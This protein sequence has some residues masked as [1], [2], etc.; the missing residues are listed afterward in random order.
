MRLFRHIK[1]AFKGLIRN[2]WIAVSTIT[3]VTITL[4][5]TGVFI[6]M[7]LNV[8][9]FTKNIESTVK[10]VAFVDSEA[11]QETVLN[12]DKQLQQIEG[13][14]LV[15]LATKEEELDKFIAYFGERG[16]IFE[17]Y[18]GE[19]N[20]L[21]TAFYIDA[22]DPQYVESITQTAKTIEGVSLVTY[23]GTSVD[24]MFSLFENVRFGMLV[25]IVGLGVLAVFLVS[26]T[27]KMSITA[28]RREIEIMRLVGA[29]NMYIRVPFMIE[30][31][32]IGV[33]GSIIPISIV[34]I[35]YQKLFISVKGEFFTSML[36]LIEPM[37]FVVNVSSYLLLAGVAVGLVG[38]VM[39][40]GRHLK[41]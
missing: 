21:K 9:H 18:R 22:K 24:K 3:A 31:V 41:I 14:E 8:T 19:N 6:L 11:T 35:G 15:T 40:V 32:V 2:G 36:Q 1:S 10:I 38:S 25:A 4:I 34:V 27:I 16:E 30:G 26:N 33:L 37:P 13:V 7:A 29:S 23:G 28:R 12:I 5:I 20:P 17:S 39:S